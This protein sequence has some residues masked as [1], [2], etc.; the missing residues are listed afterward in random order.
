VTS[1]TLKIEITAPAASTVAG[2]VEPV[3][4]S[5][6]ADSPASWPSKAAAGC[7]ATPT[8][9]TATYTVV[10]VM[11]AKMIASGIVRRGSRT[12]SPAVETASS[13]M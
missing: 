10:T 4:S 9:A 6:I 12:S 13:P 2:H 5:R 3:T 11:S 1:V 7:A 8:T